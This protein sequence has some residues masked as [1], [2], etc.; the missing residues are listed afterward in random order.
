[1]STHRREGRKCLEN[2]KR[3]ENHETV[4]IPKEKIRKIYK[5][6]KDCQTAENGVTSRFRRSN[7]ENQ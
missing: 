1:M 5:K 3:V 6:E 2:E 4:K 7:H